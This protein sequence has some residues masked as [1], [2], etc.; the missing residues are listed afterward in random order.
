MEF[1]N[2]KECRYC[3]S[4]LDNEIECNSC[5]AKISYSQLQKIK[6]LNNPEKIILFGNYHVGFTERIK[7][8]NTR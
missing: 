4:L 2:P 1:N 6:Q 5:G 8:K 7:I 3:K